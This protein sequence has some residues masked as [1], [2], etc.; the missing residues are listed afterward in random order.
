MRKNTVV[1]GA[2]LRIK[3]FILKFSNLIFK[4]RTVVSRGPIH[5]KVIRLKSRDFLGLQNLYL[6]AEMNDERKKMCAKMK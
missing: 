2:N 1:E 5:R 3:K 6:E 4:I